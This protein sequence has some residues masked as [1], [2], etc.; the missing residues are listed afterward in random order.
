MYSKSFLQKDG[1]E[2]WA[3]QGAH[4]GKLSSIANEYDFVVFSFPY[5]FHQIGEQTVGTKGRLVTNH[6]RFIDHKKR[7]VIVISLSNEMEMTGIRIELAVDNTMD[8]KCFSYRITG[9][10]FGCTP[11][12]SYEKRSVPQYPGRFHQGTHEGCF[13]RSCVSL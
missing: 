8:G 6:R 5:I 2:G 7:F 4:R 9:H 12:W 1:I 10:H 3:Q 13:S 11:G